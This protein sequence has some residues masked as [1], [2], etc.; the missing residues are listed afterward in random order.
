MTH[1][2]LLGRLI[3]RLRQLGAKPS[4]SQSPSEGALKRGEKC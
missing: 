4:D 2:N 3:N 1:F